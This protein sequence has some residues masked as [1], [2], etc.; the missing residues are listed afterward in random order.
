MKFIKNK[1][2]GS[3]PTCCLGLGCIKLHQVGLSF[4]KLL[5]DAVILYIA[6]LTVVALWLL[7][8]ISL[9]LKS[10]LTTNHLQSFRCIQ[11]SALQCFA[12]LQARRETGS[13]MH[14]DLFEPRPHHRELDRG[15]CARWLLGCSESVTV[16]CSGRVE[17]RS[18]AGRSS[19][20]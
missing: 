9:L 1:D 4:I 17:C 10:P 7:A 11:I 16:S 3:A 15:Q 13:L 5:L 14:P 12:L 2:L 8:F 6:I 18:M 20:D 19:E